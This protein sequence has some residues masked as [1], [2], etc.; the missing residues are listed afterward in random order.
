M[1]KRLLVPIS[2]WWYCLAPPWVR[3]NRSRA[4]S[5]PSL[6]TVM[7]PSPQQ[8]RFL[9]G[10]KENALAQLNSPAMRHSPPIFCRA[11][12]AWAASSM[13]RRSCRSATACNRSM[14]AIWPNKWTGTIARVLDVTA[15]STASGSMLKV[16][17]SIS[18]NTGLPPELAMAPA[19][20]K[21]VN[22]VVMTSSPVASSSA[23]SGSNS[24]SVPLAHAMPCSAAESEAIACSSSPTCSPMMN[25]W[26]S[27]TSRTAVMVSSLID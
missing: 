8:P 15:A 24:A 5:S 10:K 9:L 13:I 21:N 11:P 27:I 26:L 2:S 19:V 1:S 16:S 12:I 17:G 14:G 23:L 18:T 7:P 25:R 6:V 4:A 22:G 20:A 3:N